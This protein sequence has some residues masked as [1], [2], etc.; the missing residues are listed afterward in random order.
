MLT[1]EILWP[2]S[3]EHLANFPWPYVTLI[4]IVIFSEYT[5]EANYVLF[6]LAN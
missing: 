1:G 5:V 2:I 6:L 4:F 3:P